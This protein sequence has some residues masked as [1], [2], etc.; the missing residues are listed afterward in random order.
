M[1]SMTPN[2]HAKYSPSG[3]DRWMTCPGSLAAEAAHENTTSDFADEGTAAHELCAHCLEHGL[4]PWDFEGEKIKVYDGN[5]VWLEM[6]SPTEHKNL[7]EWEVGQDMIEHVR[8]YLELVMSYME[9]KGAILYVEKRVEFSHYVGIANQFGTADAIVVTPDEIICIDFKYGRGVL[10]KATENRQLRLYALGCLH[11]YG[12]MYNFKTVRMVVHQPRIQNLSEWDC[13]IEE[14]L[15]FGEEA[16]IAAQK[17][18]DIIKIAE[19]GQWGTPAVIPPAML[20]PTEK[21]CKFCKHKGE[22][23]ALTA[24]VFN[25]VVDQFDDITS[26]P[27]LRD[28]VESAI[29]GLPDLEH[30]ILSNNMEMV[31]LIEDWIKGVRQAVYT[32]L[33]GGDKVKDYKLVR[34]KMGNRAWTD[35]DAAEA[36]LK[37]MKTRQTDMYK[38]K[39]ITPTDAER[40]FVKSKDTKSVKRWNRLQSVITRKEGALSVAHASDP[41]DAE[42]L[43]DVSDLFDDVETGEFI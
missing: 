42:G 40:L 26:E 23:P 28:A 25:T 38:M 15:A 37:S 29:E 27:E 11:T 24:K 13:T 18:Q 16:R 14:L 4:D 34:G 9:L 17:A 21:G 36:M 43:A 39:I 41:R 2:A 32:R 5:A 19:G 1:T 30:T 8:D 22:C 3:A 6:P 31:D 20:N 7:S 33:M 35:K 12:L 10:V